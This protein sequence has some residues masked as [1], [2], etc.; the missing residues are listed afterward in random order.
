M[1]QAKPEDLTYIAFMLNVREYTRRAGRHTGC[2][3]CGTGYCPVYLDGEADTINS[4]PMSYDFPCPK[5]GTAPPETLPIY[6]DD[7]GS[8]HL[9]GLGF[10][11]REV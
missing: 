9:K 5:C 4:R 7:P 10:T 6:F 8:P 1:R 11:G 3:C 2:P